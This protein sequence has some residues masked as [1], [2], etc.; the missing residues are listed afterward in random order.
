MG[1]A[2][3]PRI[4][5]ASAGFGEGHNSAARNLAL[6]LQEQARVLVTD[7]C[8]EGAPWLNEFLRSGY[9]FITTHWPA[10]WAHCYRGVEKRDFSK[11]QFAFMRSAESALHET[12]TS[13]SPDVMV[14]TYPLYP[15]FMDRTRRELGCDIPIA[16]V[17]T[18]S[19]EINAA[20]RNAP[21][22]Y[23]LVTDSHTRG[24]LIDRGLARGRVVETG[25]PVHPSFAELPVLAADDRLA[26]GD[27]IFGNS[28]TI[29]RHDN[30]GYGPRIPDL[31][32]PA[33][34][35]EREIIEPPWPPAGSGVGVGCWSCS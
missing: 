24:Q 4:L 27:V 22:D 11:R 19:I 2:A 32:D 16:T 12:I 1:Q 14:S 5:I 35:F 3:R 10:L 6:A 9:R 31:L 7:P 8:A 18:D 25:F 28:L 26:L 13:F 21:T 17:V 30:Q 23:W 34:R 20:W 15:Y 33:H 29:Q